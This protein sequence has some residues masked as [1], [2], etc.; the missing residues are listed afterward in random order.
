MDLMPHTFNKW[1]LLGHINILLNVYL[2]L[3]S[4]ID[5]RL[6]VR[7]I[8]MYFK[9]EVHREVVEKTDKEVKKMEEEILDLVE[10]LEEKHQTLP[11]FL[12]F[13]LFLSQIC[14]K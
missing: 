7:I 9:V 10:K 1:P 6:K 12:R 11:S 14:F 5:W 8:L 4:Y 13:I 2:L 3:F